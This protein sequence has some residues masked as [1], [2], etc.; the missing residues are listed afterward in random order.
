MWNGL[1]GTVGAVPAGF[2]EEVHV[3]QPFLYQINTPVW[4]GIIQAVL[5]V[6]FLVCLLYSRESD[7]RGAKS[8]EEEQGE[9]AVQIDEEKEIP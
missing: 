1:L 3:P 4:I 6:S 8:D 5:V 7:V 2:P 9:S